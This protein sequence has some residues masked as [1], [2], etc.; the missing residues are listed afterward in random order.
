MT[1]A[2]SEPTTPQPLSQPA[3]TSPTISPARPP[4]RIPS[5]SAAKLQA[6]TTNISP[7]SSQRD[8]LHPIPLG[9]P[10]RAVDNWSS[11]AQSSSFWSSHL[12]LQRQLHPRRRGD[13]P[14]CEP[15]TASS[16]SLVPATQLS[17]IA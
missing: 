6:G 1:N 14:P 4:A 11:L 10:A 2:A 5:A 15:D 17:P 7:A 8:F 12:N 3:G 16:P 9:W 13:Y